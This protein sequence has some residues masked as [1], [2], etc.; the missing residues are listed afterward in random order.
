[1]KD[2]NIDKIRK[3]ICNEI[4]F[5]VLD[6]HRT[7][8][9]SPILFGDGDSFNVVLN[10]EKKKYYFTDEGDTLMH[11][12]YMGLEDTFRGRR[13]TA[14]DSIMKAFDIKTS[15]GEFYFYIEDEN[16]GYCYFRFLQGLSHIV[17]YAFYTSRENVKNL[18]MEDFYLYMNEKFGKRCVFDYNNKEHDTEKVYSVDCAVEDNTK[19]FFFGINNEAK[20]HTATITCLMFKQWNIPF[21]S[22]MIFDDQENINKK[23]V[24]RLANV[25]DKMYQTLPTAREE[26]PT[27]VKKLS[28]PIN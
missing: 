22:V 20:C 6:E 21:K 2:E 23:D 1:M 13:K 17:D 3:S 5:F 4:D 18:F 15:K 12:S 16:I 10:R 24:S 9:T 7:Q 27:Y 26:L 19:L 11:L 8:F 25:A 14:L 28:I